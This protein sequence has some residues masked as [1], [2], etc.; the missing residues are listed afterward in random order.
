ML[1]FEPT[2]DYEH[3]V[4]EARGRRLF[5]AAPD[6]SL[7]LMK[8]VGSMPHG[9]GARLEVDSPGY[10]VIRRWIEQGMPYGKPKMPA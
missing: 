8:A 1:G 7:L 10:K 6:R 9:G 2:E 3:L 4:K 5:P